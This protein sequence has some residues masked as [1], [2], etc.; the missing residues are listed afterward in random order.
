MQEIQEEMKNHGHEPVKF[1]DV[2]VWRN[3]RIV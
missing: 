1:L 2:K 3:K